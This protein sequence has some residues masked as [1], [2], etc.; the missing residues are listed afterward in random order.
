MNEVK[1]RLECNSHDT[2]INTDAICPKGASY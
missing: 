1:Q 2:Q